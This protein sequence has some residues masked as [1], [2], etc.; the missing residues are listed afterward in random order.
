MKLSQTEATL[1]VAAAKAGMDEKTGRKWRELSQL[2]SEPREPRQYRTR[3]DAFAGVWGEV[4]QLL[5]RDASVEAKTIF[6]YLCR[7]D[8][9]QFQE[10]QLRTLQRRVKRWREQKGAP[11]EVYFP[12]EHVPGRQAQSD[13]TYMNELL[14]T[15]AGHPFKHLLYHLT[16]TYSNW[17][18]G[19]VCF[20]ESYESL[21]SGVQAALWELGGVPQEHRTD[22]LTAAVRPPGSK[23]EFTE[24]YQGLL[25]HYGMKASHSSPGRGNENGDV[26]QAH[27]R[28][29]RAVQ[30]ELILRGSREFAGRVEYEAFLTGLF[31]RRNQLRRERVAAEV[32]VLGELP[33]RQLAACSK[34]VQRVSRN[35]TLNI[36]HNTY[37]VPSQL[38]GERV[39]VRIYG[40]HLE[41][42]YG[43]ALA[44]RLERLRGAGQATINYRHII[45][46]LVKKPGAFA[47]YRFQASL[48][49][50]LIFRVAYDELQRQQPAQAEREYL[51]L[52]QLAATES[53]E[54]VAAVL[55][56]LVDDGA[57]ISS[58]RVGAEVR[59]RVD[60]P[61]ASVLTVRIEPVRLESYDRLL[62]VG[63]VAA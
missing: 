38:I 62:A 33:Q 21:A 7:Q 40:G 10:R 3:L 17:E 9:A 56:A 23:E 60:Q 50:R 29:K 30:Q 16:L 53:E 24:K 4:E 58:A 35:A 32:K 2:P 46:S 26:E 59:A 57:A 14:V 54:L 45:H 47:H 34:E 51:K 15:I 42:W 11:R 27:H 63:E 25:Q 44:L 37:S 43:G 22:S 39:E 36:R 61:A 31:R 48:F 18:W 8:P 13:F 19:Q 28:F 41:V 12:Q 1:A 5:E 20:S 52:L 55:R 6:D 49:P